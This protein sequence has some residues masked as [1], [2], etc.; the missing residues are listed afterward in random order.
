MDEFDVVTCIDA[1]YHMDRAKFFSLSH[2][3]LAKSGKL[4]LTDI[5][6]SDSPISPRT[7]FI[8]QL[9]CKFTQVPNNNLL[10]TRKEYLKTVEDA[11]FTNIIIDDITENVFSGLAGHIER[12]TRLF[13]TGF[14]TNETSQEETPFAW[15]KYEYGVH[16]LVNW[17]GDGQKLRFIVVKAQ[18]VDK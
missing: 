9:I 1:L 5:L 17:L 10:V 3:R 7:R 16:W 2:N 15:N 4:S 18:K 14:G 6:L 11:G 12:Q 13:R 8:L